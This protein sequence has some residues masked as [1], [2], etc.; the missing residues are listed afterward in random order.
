MVGA[1]DMIPLLPGATLD[2]T[3]TIGEATVRVQLTNT[4]D[5]PLAL[6]PDFWV[7]LFEQAARDGQADYEWEFD[8]PVYATVARRP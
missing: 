5:E 4:L 2:E 1:D 8:V 3:R 6:D 7:G